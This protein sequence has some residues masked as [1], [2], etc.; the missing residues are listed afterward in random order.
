MW[1]HFSAKKPLNVWIK[2]MESQK[3]THVFDLT[4]DPNTKF[5]PTSEIFKCH[6][7]KR[8]MPDSASYIT[9][10]M[11]K[12]GVPSEN[13]EVWINFKFGSKVKSKS[14]FIPTQMNFHERNHTCF[15]G[16]SP[17]VHNLLEVTSHLISKL[18]RVYVKAW[19]FFV[20][21]FLS[22]HSYILV[23]TRVNKTR[24]LHCFGISSPMQ[25][26]CSLVV[27]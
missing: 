16:Y 1:C 26:S 18:D 15:Y 24:Y 17:E 22:K 23:K 6:R 3:I 27:Q 14:W 10:S 11:M 7:S 25:W 4:F 9:H 12:D 20:S 2:Y 5:I 8:L 13:S 19:R 21:G